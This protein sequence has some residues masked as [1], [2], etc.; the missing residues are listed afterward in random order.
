MKDG[1]EDPAALARRFLDLWQ[2]QVAASAADP[3]LAEMA[4]RLA[5]VPAAW[6]ALWT[7]AAAAAQHGRADDDATASAVPPHGASPAGAASG[8][9]E[10]GL[11]GLARRV[12]ELERRVAVLEAAGGGRSGPRRGARARRS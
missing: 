9:G 3:A 12:A 8:G 5:S 2:E 10:H 4:Q 1:S 11:A 6:A 7:G